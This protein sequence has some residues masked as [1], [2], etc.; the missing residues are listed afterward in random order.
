VVDN[1]S[2]ESGIMVDG[3]AGAVND[4][5]RTARRRPWDSTLR[6]IREVELRPTHWTLLALLVLTFGLRTWHLV[7]HLSGPLAHPE[8]LSTSSD[9]VA[10]ASWA[11]QIA[12]GDWLDQRH[13]HP[14]MDWMA[15]R[16]SPTQFESWWGGKEVYHQNPLYPYVLAVSY[17]LAG[18]AVPLLILQMLAS[19]FSI[20]LVFDIGRRLFDARAGLI[21]AGLAGLFAPSIVL[22]AMLLRASLHSTLTLLSVWLLFRLRDRPGLKNGARVGICL[23]A[24][25]MLRPAG[26]TLMLVGPVLLLLFGDLRRVWLRWLPALVVGAM[27][28]IA[29]FAVRNL[30]VGAPALKF[31][32]RGPA[33]ILQANTRGAEPGFMALPAPEAFRTYM[34]A[35]HRSMTAALGTA[36]DSWPDGALHWWLGLQWQKSICV[37][38]D[39]EYPNNINFYFYRRATSLLAILPTF[40]WFV[41]PGLV[42]LVL[43]GVRGR[44]KRLYLLL[45]AAAAATYL[46]CVLGFALGRYRMPLAMLMTIPAGVT[47]SFAIDALRSGDR[48]QILQ[49]VVAGLL[50]LALSV[51]SYT[52]VPRR[53]V[54]DDRGRPRTESPAQRRIV[55]QITALRSQEFALAA[56][57]LFQQGESEAATKLME[58]FL[59]EYEAF[60]DRVGPGLWELPNA[61]PAMI[62]LG[63][64]RSR[65]THAEVV[66]REAGDLTRARFYQDRAAKIEAEMKSLGGGDGVRGPPM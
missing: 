42:G 57:V 9:M 38:R 26:L 5:A 37:F 41:G 33:A 3:A 10:F 13:Y 47:V 43:L 39:Y 66:F 19:T 22:D 21:A 63:D 23:A 24:S 44:D 16:G 2:R 48:R 7:N 61:G 36:I 29:P 30:V 54:F 17:L 32:T 4:A 35:G 27:V 51:L 58:D 64:F 31:S 40:G 59:G 11:K 15:G 28:T 50:A 8:E 14:A 20:L 46:G 25:F 34:D 62:L 18:S 55:E 49:A 12:A 52:T 60:F 6:S 56:R 1:G 45:L 65:M 53:T